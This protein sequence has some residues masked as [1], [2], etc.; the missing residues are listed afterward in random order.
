MVYAHGLNDWMKI[1]NKPF[2]ESFRSIFKIGDLVEWKLYRSHS[3][4]GEIEPNIMQGIITD[5]YKAHMASR[6][7]WYAKVFEARTAQFYNMSLMTLTLLK[8]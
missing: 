3:V 1:S 8:D 4:T 7:V 6:E 2:G 5:I